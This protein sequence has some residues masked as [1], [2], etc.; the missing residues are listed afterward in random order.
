[1]SEIPEC[2][3][4]EYGK[5][6][7][8]IHIAVLALPFAIL[9]TAFCARSVRKVLLTEREARQRRQ[10]ALPTWEERPSG[11]ECQHIAEPVSLFGPI[12]GKYLC[13]PKD[14]L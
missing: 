14:C 12:S 4:Q 8:L 11:S 2:G 1:M 3:N 6:N 9:T 5:N 10:L 13:L 7:T